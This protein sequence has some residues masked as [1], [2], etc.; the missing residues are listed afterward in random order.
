M[1]HQQNTKLKQLQKNITVT[2]DGASAIK[3]N[4]GASFSSNINLNGANVTSENGT[5]ILVEGDFLNE[6]REFISETVPLFVEK[7]QPL[8][9]GH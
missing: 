5:A 6:A 2:G 8:I 1:A 3:I 4:Q 7:P 9:L